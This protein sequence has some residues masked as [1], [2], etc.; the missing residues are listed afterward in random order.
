MKNIFLTFIAAAVFALPLHGI[1]IGG[2]EL[3]TAASYVDRVEDAKGE[4]LAGEAKHLIVRYSVWLGF[5]GVWDESHVLLLSS[6]YNVGTGTTAYK[7]GALGSD[8][9]LTNTGWGPDGL[10]FDGT[11]FGTGD[12]VTRGGATFSVLAD[13]TV[14][15][16]FGS[17]QTIVSQW[18]ATGNQRSWFLEYNVS[19]LA[20]NGIFISSDGDDFGLYITAPNFPDGIYG[21]TLDGITKTEYRDGVSANLEFSD[22]GSSVENDAIFDSSAPLYVG[23][24]NEGSISLFAGTIRTTFVSTLTL[25]EPRMIENTEWLDEFRALAIELSQ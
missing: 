12:R 1:S 3:L 8:I 4:P 22:Q 13:Y 17:R 11:A 7:L 5:I 2:P 10:V 25:S 18:I 24:F 21:A 9:T 14:T 15:G 16:N 20:G 19:G 6:H 23:A